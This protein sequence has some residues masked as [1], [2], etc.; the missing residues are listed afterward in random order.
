VRSPSY[1]PRLGLE[2]PRFVDPSSNPIPV[3]PVLFHFFSSL[4]IELV[5]GIKA[6]FFQWSRAENPGIVMLRR[7]D[8][9]VSRPL[10]YSFLFFFDV[11]PLMNP[12]ISVRGITAPF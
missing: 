12:P 5:L 9:V 10:D 1:Q 11:F 2:I 6:N 8:N 4:L 3:P 7:N